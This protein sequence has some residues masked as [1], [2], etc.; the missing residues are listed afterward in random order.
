MPVFGPLQPLPCDF[1]LND[2]TS[3][4][5]PIIWGH[6]RHFLSRHNVLWA[7]AL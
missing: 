1:R 2:V 5:L 6:R 3:S 4:S 7:T